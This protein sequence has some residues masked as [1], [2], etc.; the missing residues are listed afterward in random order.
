MKLRRQDPSSRATNRTMFFLSSKGPY[1]CINCGFDEN[2]CIYRVYGKP[3]KVTSTTN[4]KNPPPPTPNTH[5]K[6]ADCLRCQDQVDNYVELDNCILFLDATLQKTRFYRHILANCDYSNK[7]PIKLAVIFSLCDSYLQWSQTNQESDQGK[8]YVELEFSFYVIFAQAMAESLLLYLIIFAFFIC[9]VRQTDFK[10]ILSS[11]VICSYGK[12]F[13]L[14]AVLW[15]A[16]VKSI[17]DVLLE[18]IFLL[19][20][21]QCCRVIS[22]NVLTLVRASLIV[23]I[24]KLIHTAVIRYITTMSPYW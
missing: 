3:D 18:F 5:L 20:L 19:S 16:E 1:T 4:N 22:K 17:T 23:I 12:L 9:F 24:S 13:H 14:P 10:K 11:L 15:S 6:L 7:V 21:A 2:S 8:S